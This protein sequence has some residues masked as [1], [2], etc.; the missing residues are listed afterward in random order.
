[1]SNIITLKELCDALQRFDET[2]KV[3]IA[4]TDYIGFWLERVG[5]LTLEFVTAWD[6]QKRRCRLADDEE[7]SAEV[8]VVIY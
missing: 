6:D 7:D 5:S 8:V 4:R 3:L 2:S 1:M